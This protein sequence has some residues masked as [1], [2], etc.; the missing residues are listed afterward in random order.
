MTE[1]GL[2]VAR[3]SVQSRHY[4]YILI[5]KTETFIPWTV[6]EISFWYSGVLFWPVC[7]PLDRYDS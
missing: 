7:L 6:I 5:T 3:T 4:Y 1:L 2:V